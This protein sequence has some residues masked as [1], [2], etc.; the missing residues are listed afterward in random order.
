MPVPMSSGDYRAPK[1]GY[2]YF[3]IVPGLEDAT[4]QDWSKLKE[5]A[6]TGKCVGFGEYWVANPLDDY[7]NPH[8][9][10]DVRVHKED[11]TSRPEPY[12]IPHRRG[13][14]LT[15]DNSDPDFASLAIKLTQSARN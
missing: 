1:R 6:G 9:S 7:G 5:V 10:F 13:I 8:H 12:P 2:L 11:E 4:R 14:V 15:G 3:S